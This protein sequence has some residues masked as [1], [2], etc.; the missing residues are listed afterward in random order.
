MEDARLLRR[1]ALS[2][3]RH[4]PG[5]GKQHRDSAFAHASN[6]P[7]PNQ[8]TEKAAVQELRQKPRYTKSE[9]VVDMDRQSGARF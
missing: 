5:P 1:K 4:G 7:A 8:Y 3:L 9:Y 6:T 2:E